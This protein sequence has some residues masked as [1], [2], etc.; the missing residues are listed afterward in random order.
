MEHSTEH[1]NIDAHGLGFVISCCG[2]YPVSFIPV[3]KDLLTVT[4]VINAI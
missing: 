3:F 1:P 2:L 4:W